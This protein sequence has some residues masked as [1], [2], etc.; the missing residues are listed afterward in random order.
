MA[1]FSKFGRFLVVATKLLD[2]VFQ[3]EWNGLRGCK[4]KVA[5]VNR[6]KLASSMPL[7]VCIS[8]SLE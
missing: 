7:I 4:L 2:F 3:E 8:S 1:Y 5:N 6:E